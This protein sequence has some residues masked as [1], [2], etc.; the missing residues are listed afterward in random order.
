MFLA[1]LLPHL[2]PVAIHFMSFV[3]KPF[4]AVWRIDEAEHHTSLALQGKH[5]VGSILPHHFIYNVRIGIGKVEG[6]KGL[7]F[8]RNAQVQFVGIIEEQNG[9]KQRALAHTLGADEMHIAVESYLGIRDVCAVQ[10]Y[11]FV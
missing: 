5:A 1:N 2:A 4:V 6:I 8:F 7:L 3:N 10:K 11:D 9:S